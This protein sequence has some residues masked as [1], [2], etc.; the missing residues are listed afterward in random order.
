M[1]RDWI[2]AWGMVAGHRKDKG[3][4]AELLTTLD[5]AGKIQEL[6]GWNR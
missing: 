1:A 4:T 6:I 2:L 3:R 5:F